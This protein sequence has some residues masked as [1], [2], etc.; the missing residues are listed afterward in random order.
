M[1]LQ[2]RRGVGAASG[3]ELALRHH[4]V[5]SVLLSF[6]SASVGS[7]FVALLYGWRPSCAILLAR[8]V[9]AAS[10]PSRLPIWP[11]R[12]NALRGRVGY[13]AVYTLT[14]RHGAPG[15]AAKFMGGAAYLA[16]TTDSP[17]DPTK[18]RDPAWRIPFGSGLPRPFSSHR[19][20]STSLP[21]SDPTPSPANGPPAHRHEEKPG[22][23]TPCGTCERE[24][25]SYIGGENLYPPWPCVPP[26]R[27]WRM[28][29]NLPIRPN[30]RP[31]LARSDTPIQVITPNVTA[32]NEGAACVVPYL[33]PETTSGPTTRWGDIARVFQSRIPR[34][35]SRE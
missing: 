21:P 14:N 4:T 17:H 24:R 29:R 34:H 22:V 2:Q 18:C 15:R 19:A 13:C 11:S 27:R 3:L 25:L 6:P 26:Q 9:F 28:C 5:P 32:P 30:G 12:R 1:S 10:T 7:V 31:F 33:I 16:D 8:W 23:S 20:P 35:L